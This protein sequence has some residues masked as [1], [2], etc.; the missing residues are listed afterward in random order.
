MKGNKKI[1][2]KG[3]YYRTGLRFLVMQ[4]AYKFQIKGFIKKIDSDEYE[5]YAQGTSEQVNR[6]IEYLQS[7]FIGTRTDELIVENIIETEVF[8][9]FD[10][11]S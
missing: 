8:E 1:I 7:G 9:T 6:F 2:L 5:V 4:S 3:R 11:Q 10:I